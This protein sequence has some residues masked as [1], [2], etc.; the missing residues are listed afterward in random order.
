MASSAGNLRGRMWERIML[1]MLVKTSMYKMV[2]T[3]ARRVI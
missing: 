3:Y 1:E 2:R